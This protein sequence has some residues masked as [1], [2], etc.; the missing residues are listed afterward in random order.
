MAIAWVLNIL[1]LILSTGGAFWMIQYPLRLSSHEVDDA[2]TKRD[3]VSWR[4]ALY[5][6]A[7]GFLLQ[8]IGTLIAFVERF[9]I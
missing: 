6:L 2:R 3:R 8:L 5:L 4:R 9:W 7:N 1:G